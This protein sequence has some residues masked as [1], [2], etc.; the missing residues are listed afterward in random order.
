[1]PCGVNA[2]AQRCG[3]LSV[4]GAICEQSG[5]LSLTS[6][7]TGILLTGVFVDH[8]ELKTALLEMPAVAV[9]GKTDHAICV[10]LQVEERI[11]HRD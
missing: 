9:I 2:D 6:S 7:E 8:N 3:D 1:M 10:A 5:D 4:R 11:A